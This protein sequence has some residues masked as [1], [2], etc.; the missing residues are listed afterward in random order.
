M[1]A[2]CPPPSAPPG[3]PFVL[4]SHAAV[5]LGVSTRTLRRYIA[6]GW[7]RT[8]ENGQRR[9]VHREDVEALLRER[10][11]PHGIGFNEV[12]FRML[13]I[14]A[15]FQRELLDDAMEILEVARRRLEVSP[16]E[17]VERHRAA[18][19]TDAAGVDVS[20]RGDWITFLLRLELEHLKTLAKRGIPNP[21]A[22]FLRV[23]QRLDDQ[24][25]GAPYWR[26]ARA[27]KRNVEAL[28]G[29]W[30]IESGGGVQAFESA[31]NGT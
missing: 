29:A 13:V 26:M 30:I 17:L 10:S 5:A 25:G 4:R 22:A 14:E 28:A 8:N 6:R 19:K 27:A 21:W 12:N 3:S 31:T 16:A 11:T 18:A 9:E 24:A 23:A 2:T 7:L 15:R 1:R 20:T